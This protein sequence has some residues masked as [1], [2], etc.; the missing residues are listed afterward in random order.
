VKPHA[1]GGIGTPGH[2]FYKDRSHL[3]AVGAQRLVPPLV[4]SLR[5]PAA[6]DARA[7]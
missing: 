4:R 7:N 1:R 6:L 3:S 2:P 5:R